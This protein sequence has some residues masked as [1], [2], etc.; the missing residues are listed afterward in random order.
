MIAQ[1]KWSC[2]IN[3]ADEWQLQPA[4]WWKVMRVLLVSYSCFRNI[5]N[6][7]SQCDFETYFIPTVGTP[8]YSASGSLENQKNR[9]FRNNWLIDRS[10]SSSI[11]FLL[12]KNN[13]LA[14]A[15]PMHDSYEYKFVYR[16]FILQF[17]SYC[18]IDGGC[19]THASTI[20][21][22]DHRRP[23]TTYLLPHLA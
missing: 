17:L 1:S 18:L 13:S 19:A 16:E 3:G 4:V 23:S 8:T 2:T 11:L 15:A 14:T 10:F 21:L 9:L 12:T 20:L 7:I 5:L 22:L 6:S